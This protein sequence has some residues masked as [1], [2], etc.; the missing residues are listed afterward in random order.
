M[1]DEG[2]TP[3]KAKEGQV[4]LV[5]VWATWCGP[6]QGPMQHNQEMLT[7]N[8]E[9]WGDK[10][11]IVGVSVDEDKET[12]KER[13]NSRDWKAIQHLTLGGWDGNHGLVKD[14]GIQGIPFVCLVD[15]F[16]RINFT[17]HP[18]SINLEE[19]IN[20]LLEASAPT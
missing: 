10:V 2:K 12:I 1:F 5:D 13:V 19:R 11:T 18:S 4:M 16:S 3:L 20:Q 14:F 8:K 15:K 9:R 6:C 7:K 17:G